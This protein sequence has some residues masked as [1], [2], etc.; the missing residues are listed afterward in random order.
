MSKNNRISRILSLTLIF[1]MVFSFLPTGLYHTEVHADTGPYLINITQAEADAKAMAAYGSTETKLPADGHFE[2]GNRNDYENYYRHGAIYSYGICRGNDVWD[3]ANPYYSNNTSPY[4]NGTKHFFSSKKRYYAYE[5]AFNGSGECVFIDATTGD[6]YGEYSC[7]NSKWDLTGSFKIW[8]YVTPLNISINRYPMNTSQQQ[9]D[10][11]AKKF[12]FG[13]TSATF[14]KKTTSD[15]TRTQWTVD[16]P[17]RPDRSY[18]LR[19][20]GIHT[21]DKNEYGGRGWWNLKPG[22]RYYLYSQ[23]VT[24]NA[25]GG[26]SYYVLF[27]TDTGEEHPTGDTPPWSFVKSLF[28]I[29]DAVVTG[30][31]NKNYTGD[32]IAQKPVVKY[33]GSTLKLNRDYVL[34]YSNN[35]W[36]GTATLKIYGIGK[37]AGEK[38]VTFKITEKQVPLPS[39]AVR[40]YGNSRYATANKITDQVKKL[41]GGERFSSIIVATGVNYPDALAGSYLAKRKNAPILI[42]SPAE[43]N[44]VVNYIKKNLASGGKVYILGGIGA[45]PNSFVRKLNSSGLKHK[46]L[47]G[48]SRYETNLKILD[49]S[50][51]FGNELIVVTGKNFPD[52]LSA[53]AAGRP[54]LLVGDTL[55]PAQKTFLNKNKFSKITIIGGTVAVSNKV[56]SE[57]SKYG[58]TG[59]VSGSSRYETSAKVAKKYFGSTKHVV[60][61]IGTN[62]PDALTGGPLALK[63]NAPM[64]LTNSHVKDYTYAR[65]YRKSAGATSAYVL[66]GP[67]LVSNN[68]VAN[69]LK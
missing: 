18:T 49:E 41:N 6:V 54:I 58:T 3:S 62:Y 59:R 64:I 7:M 50:G 34:E 57:L 11:L 2:V 66:G 27:D 52:A 65:S 67:T 1:M 8:D 30:V 43:E 37:Y 33:K 60:L 28:H 22:R 40:V 29:E 24:Y 48:A 10:N 42:T 15:Y 61:A 56:K 14:K 25:G 68:A 23:N 20:W 53:S 5:L 19:Y 36:P 12:F 9:A 47:G 4:W 13:N 35:V 32:V 39:N 38:T 63:L 69:I 17:S 21:V 31:I 26:T 51:S 16:V 55:T 45:V 46:R 44:N